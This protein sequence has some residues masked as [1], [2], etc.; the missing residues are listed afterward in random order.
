MSS[1]KYS[2]IIL[3]FGI[4]VCKKSGFEIIIEVFVDGDWV[5]PH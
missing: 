4:C 5:A 3:F 1:H 2:F